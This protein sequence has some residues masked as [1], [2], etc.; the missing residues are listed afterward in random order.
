[1]RSIVV[2]NEIVAN[3][4][5]GSSFEKFQTGSILCFSYKKQMAGTRWSWN[6]KNRQKTGMREIL[7]LPVQRI[8]PQLLFQYT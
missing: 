4:N 8:F 2:Y 3:R 6:K 5:E 7:V 1:M